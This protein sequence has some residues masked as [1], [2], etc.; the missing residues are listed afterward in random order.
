[1]ELLGHRAQYVVAASFSRILVVAILICV[2]LFIALL[3]YCVLGEALLGFYSTA[4]AKTAQIT[5]VV[6]LGVLLIGIVAGV[7]ILDIV[8]ACLVGA[9]LL[10]TILENY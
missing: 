6:G 3:A 9:V 5:F 2:A 10:G 7:R 4:K 8:G 1:M